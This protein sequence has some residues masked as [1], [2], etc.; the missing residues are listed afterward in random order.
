M[1]LHDLVLKN[2]SYRRFQQDQKIERAVLEALV[3]L[4]RLSASAANLQPLKYMLSCDVETNAT[5]FPH[6]AW[7]GH[8]K[9]WAGP[10][11]GERPA[12]YIVISGD[13][14]ISKNFGCDHG[15]AAQSILLGAA[16]IGIGGCMISSVKRQELAEALQISGRYEILLVLALG[17]P[18]ET[19]ELVSVPPDGSTKYY[20]DTD[21]VH[22]V[23]KRSLSEIIL[24]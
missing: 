17:I 12:A 11:E 7:A 2:R 8:L 4:G 16:E 18:G 21:G 20:R 10:C 24:N 9:E 6:L 19:V 5:I 15:I 22:Y 14:D 3:D 1:R 23:P 13:T